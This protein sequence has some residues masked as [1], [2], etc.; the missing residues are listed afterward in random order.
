MRA[1]EGRGAGRRR[2]SGPEGGLDTG[3]DVWEGPAGSTRQ[4]A[5]P[6]ASLPTFS[7]PRTRL[8]PPGSRLTPGRER[9]T[10][11]GGRFR[12]GP[13]GEETR[14]GSPGPS[15]SLARAVGGSPLEPRGLGSRLSDGGGALRPAGRRPHPG[16]HHPAPGPLTSPSQPP[17]PPQA[18]LSVRHGRSAPGP[19][20]PAS[21]RSRPGPKGARLGSATCVQQVPARGPAPGALPSPLQQRSA[22][23]EARPRPRRAPRPAPTEPQLLRPGRRQPRF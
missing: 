7:G 19:A 18:G 23:S 20:Q 10:R 8:R 22:L 17:Q 6:L 15:G 11:P 1:K 5:A 14:P 16:Q 3:R 2:R 9:R 4:R 21:M 13:G 12:S